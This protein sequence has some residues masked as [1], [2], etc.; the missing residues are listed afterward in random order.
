[1]DHFFNPK[2]VA[3]VGASAKEGKVGYDILKNILQYSYSGAVYPVNPKADTILGQK[4]YPDLLSIPDSID[5]VVVS[6]P[7]QGVLDV[8]RQCKEKGVD[9]VVVITAGFKEVG[10]AGG[11]LEEALVKVPFEII[12]Q[13]TDTRPV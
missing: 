8:I 7:P 2:S 9:S 12:N 4:V 6:V 13:G 5:L 1:M 10:G 11:H 3:I